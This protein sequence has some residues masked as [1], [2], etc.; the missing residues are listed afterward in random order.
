MLAESTSAEPLAPRFEDRARFLCGARAVVGEAGAVDD[1]TLR[2]DL[3]GDGRVVDVGAVDGVV[4]WADGGKSITWD[5]GNHFHRL[6]LAD[7]MK[8]A[9]EQKQEAA[10]KEE[11][12][13]GESLG[14]NDGIISK[15]KKYSGRIYNSIYRKNTISQLY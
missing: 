5:L 8:F 15:N 12:T 11:A 6:S 3:D 1:V 7:A 13:L 10:K 2:V 14:L 4:A 9:E